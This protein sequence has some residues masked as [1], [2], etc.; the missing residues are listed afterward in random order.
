M[1]HF[2]TERYA[3]LWMTEAGEND[4]IH[5]TFS[6]DWLVEEQKTTRYWSILLSTQDYNGGTVG[7]LDKLVVGVLLNMK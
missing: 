6:Q 2:V 5:A 4:Q 1:W 7:E 3:T